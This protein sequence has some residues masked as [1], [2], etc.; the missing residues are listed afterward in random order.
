MATSAPDQLTPAP[1]ESST[2]PGVPGRSWHRG[3]LDAPCRAADRH[4]RPSDLQTPAPQ[5]N[6]P[7]SHHLHRIWSS[8][9]SALLQRRGPDCSIE[10]PLARAAPFLTLAGPERRVAPYPRNARAR[11]DRSNSEY[12]RHTK[13][14]SFMLAG[15]LPP[16][17][18]TRDA[19]RRRRSAADVDE[20]GVALCHEVGCEA[21]AYSAVTK[22]LAD[23]MTRDGHQALRRCRSHGPAGTSPSPPIS[24][25]MDETEKRDALACWLPLRLRMRSPGMAAG[26]FRPRVRS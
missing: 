25:Q 10:S 24:S 19:R 14:K 15:E 20:L 17:R 12:R 23:R 6:A 8:A 7:G 11:L 22:V 9:S 18:Q 26:G 21:G 13:S 16:P 4:P 3:A 5:R 1:A 2:P